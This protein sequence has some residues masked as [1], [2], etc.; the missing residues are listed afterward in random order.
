M[1]EA[2]GWHLVDAKLA[3]SEQ[4]AMSGDHVERGVHQH[5]HVEAK[6]TD[7]F[8]NLPDLLLAVP[9]RVCRVRFKLG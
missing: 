6:D 1:L 4:P 2:Q 5:R 3:A 7:A 9:A 8:S